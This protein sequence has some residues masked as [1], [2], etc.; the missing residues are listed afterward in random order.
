MDSVRRVL[1]SLGVNES[2]ITQ[3]SFGERTTGGNPQS[4]LVA[5][6]EFIRSNTVCEFPAGPSLLDVAETNGVVIPFGCRQGQC[7]TCATRVVSGV[8][9]MDTDAGL[10]AEQKRAGYV[11]PCVSRAAGNV[12]VQA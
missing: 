2:R 8:V 6:V 3:E 1:T 9:H 4:Q 7:G 12:V 11:L 5:T 10:T